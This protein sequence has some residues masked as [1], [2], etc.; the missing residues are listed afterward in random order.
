MFSRVWVVQDA[1]S[2][3]FLAPSDDGDVTYTRFLKYAG[4]FDDEEAA[5]DTAAFHCTDGF[6][7]AS[8][9]EEYD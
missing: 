9:Y 7:I 2:G 6:S 8:F 1:E 4:R 5:V 3:E